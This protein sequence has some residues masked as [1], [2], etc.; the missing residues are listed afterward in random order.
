M[1]KRLKASSTLAAFMGFS[2]SAVAQQA[3][4]VDQA[5][6][7]AEVIV[8][9]SSRRGQAL[10]DMA[11][12]ARVFSEAQLEVLLQ[13]TTSVQEILGKAVPG[14][15]PPVT[16]GSAGSLTLR[17]RDPLFLID[18]VPLA[19][20]TNFNRFL[21][22]FDP[23]AIGRVEVV[24]GP[25]AL[26]GSGATGGVIQFFTQEPKDGRLEF[27]AFAQTRAFATKK[28]A[29]DDDGLTYKFAGSING[30]VTDWLS[31]YGLVSYERTG[32]N[33]RA[34]GDLLTGRSSF[35]EDISFFGKVR[36]QLA[37]GQSLTG[38]F[39]RTS[40]NFQDRT[41]E[42]TEV[43][44]G[45]GTV[46]AGE[47]AFPFSYAEEPTN[48]FV[49]GN[50]K[51]LNEDL[52]GGEL[53][54][55]GY[56][57][58]S[59]FLNPG[60][61]IRAALS[62]NGGPF[63]GTWPGLF[64]TGRIT[65]EFGARAQY[66]RPIGNRMNFA[67]GADYNDAKSDSL[68]IISSV[69]DFDQTGFFDA[70]TEADQ[71]PPFDLQSIGVFWEG[72]FHVT[73]RFTLSGGLRW[74]RFA[75][76]VGEYDVVF[77]FAPGIRPG[78][79]ANADGISLNIGA[80]YDFSDALTVFGN[81]SEGFATPALGFLF[82]NVPPGTSV[83]DSNLIEPVVTKSFELGFRGAIGTL[84]YAFGAYY[85]QSDFSTT[86][87]VDP[88]TGLANR[89]RA[90]VDIAGLEVSAQW[91]PT[92][93]FKLEANITYIDGEVDTTGQGDFVPLSTQDNPPLKFSLSPSYAFNEGQSI[94]GQLLHVASRD[95]AFEAGIDANPVESYTL[96]DAGFNQ[97]IGAGLLSLQVTNLLNE[98]YV[99]AG[100]ISFI[101]GRIRSGLG[102]AVSLS[103][104]YSF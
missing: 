104:G 14:F 88:A 80:T 1:S 97:A 48:E 35:V 15:A 4:P 47:A 81:Y 20:N 28:K 51:Y 91:Q 36:A 59:E 101:P 83:A 7:D 10:E 73:D 53:S 18:G 3:A 92:M 95:G 56:Y 62:T 49:Y 63:P 41:F 55:L 22:K 66:A 9:E 11:R 29:F 87:S 37:K 54:V 13:Q 50:L 25:T 72:E 45:D 70:S 23:L 17:G 42:L 2:A 24:Y 27:G 6:S 75:Y 96:I 5:Y 16:E 103:F 90:P 60:S 65:E 71:T 61:D 79:S 86:V 64:Q 74:D 32:G 52:A 8:I 94:F 43:N 46:I 57:S 77:T 38:T 82:N 21:D 99:P 19:S 69:T 85:T 40:L 78:G 39:S 89:T 34:E 26:Y 12:S 84:S 33:F 76:D 93:A 68:L 58:E 100:E 67:I 31:V 102:R 44:A 98:D 30:A